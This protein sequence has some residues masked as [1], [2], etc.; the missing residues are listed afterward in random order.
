M[1]TKNSI[2]KYRGRLPLLSQ[3]LWKKYVKETGDEISYEEFTTIIVAEIREIKNWVLKEP[4]GF[5]M[6]EIGNITINK[7]KPGSDYVTYLYNGGKTKIKNHNIHTG[8]CIF[9]IQWFRRST[10]HKDRYAYW[11]FSASRE[12]KRELGKQLKSGKYPN[13]NCF[14]QD[15]FVKK[16]K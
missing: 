11:Y 13:Y 14:S 5:Q 9:R 4:I 1:P 3:K 7:F 12:F 16:N 10:S 15:H 8:G 2:S 6:S